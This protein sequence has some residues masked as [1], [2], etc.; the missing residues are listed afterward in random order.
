MVAAH[1]LRRRG[2]QRI[3]AAHSRR[4][5]RRD[6]RGSPPSLR[7]WQQK[8]QTSRPGRPYIQA[9][10]GFV[11]A[12]DSE[13]LPRIVDGAF[14]AMVA[15]HLLR[16]VS[17]S[18]SIKLPAPDGHRSKPS[19]ASFCVEEL[20]A[21]SPALLENQKNARRRRAGSGARRPEFRPVG[22]PKRSPVPKPKRS[23]HGRCGERIHY[24]DALRRW[25]SSSRRRRSS[26]SASARMVSRL[27]RSSCWNSARFLRSRSSARWL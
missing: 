16:C 14:A 9:V 2:R 19:G 24:L 26:C 8:H 3:A 13:L 23:P 7:F 10:R 22:R 6:G 4:S 11:G 18:T 5:F 20:L 27:R 17:G 1:L 25:F 21:V 15:A 12:A